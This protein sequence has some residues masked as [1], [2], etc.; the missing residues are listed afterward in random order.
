MVTQ[1]TLLSSQIPCQS[2]TNACYVKKHFN[3]DFEIEMELKEETDFIISQPRMLFFMDIDGDGTPEI[4]ASGYDDYHAKQVSSNTIIFI[5]SKSYQIKKKMKTYYYNDD[6]VNSLQVVKINSDFEIIIAVADVPE[7]PSNLRRRLVCYRSDNSI[8]WIS[9]DVLP[10]GFNNVSLADFNQDGIP[11]V[12]SYNQIYNADNGVL[13]LD[14]GN[15]YFN[16]PYDATRNSVAVNMD[17]NPNDLELVADF[18]VSKIIIT[19]LNGTSGNQIIPDIIIP[20]RNKLEMFVAVADMNLDGKLD[21]IMIGGGN[22]YISTYNGN[23]FEIITQINYN[24]Y[25]NTITIGNVNNKSQPCLI[26]NNFSGLTK[27]SLDSNNQLQLDWTYEPNEYYGVGCTLF[28]FDNDGI[29]E[30]LFRGNKTF[31][32]ISAKNDIPLELTKY[33]CGSILP[34]TNSPV[35]GDIDGTGETKICVPCT[36]RQYSYSARLTIFGAPEGQ[37]WA[38]ARRIWNHYLYNPLFINDDGTVPQYMHDIATYKNGKYNNF[39]AQESLL[40]EDGNYLAPAASLTGDISCIDYDV[41]SDSYTIHFSIHNRLDASATATTGVPISF[42]DGASGDMLGTFHTDQPIVAN[43]TAGTYSY[44]ISAGNIQTLYMVVNTD[45]YPLVLTDTI[46]YDIDECDYHDN[47]FITDLPQIE[48]TQQEICAGDPYEWWGTTLTQS[49][50]YTHRQLNVSGCDSIISLLQL[51]VTQLKMSEQSQSSCDTYT[52][53]EQTYDHSGSYTFDTQSINGCDSIAT[54]HLTLHHST[55]TE[56]QAESCD[57]Y[58]WNGQTYTQSGQYTY[59]GRTS[60]GCDSTVLVKLT[61]HPSTTDTLHYATCE[62]YQWNGKTYTQSGDYLYQGQTLHGCDS[63]VTLSLIIS[64]D[65]LTEER[66]TACDTYT[67]NGQTYDHSGSYTL[68]TQSING[69]DSIVTLQLTIHPSYHTDEQLITC[70]SISYLGQ[71]LDQSGVYHFP[72]QSSAGC[73]SIVTLDFI[74]ATSQ[75]QYPQTSCGAYLWQEDQQTY[76]QSGDYEVHYTNI[77]GCDSTL[78]L[79]LTIHPTYAKEITA[80]G[81]GSYQWQGQQYLQSGTYT[82]HLTTRMHCDSTLTLRLLI[83]AESEKHD[84]VTTNE[85]YYWEI[86]G[87]TYSESGIY[88]QVY[89]SDHQCDSIHY[90][91]LSIK[92]GTDIYFPNVINTTSGG[93]GYFTGYSI[94]KPV[95]I[96]VLTVYD[97]WGN[98]VYQADHLMTNEPQSGWDGTY[99]GR[100][101]QQG[102][103]VWIA[104]VRHRD[105]SET[106]YTGDVT[107]IR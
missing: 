74:I 73:D 43:G 26:L 45:Q 50:S 95:E 64:H 94:G 30:I 2:D 33:P 9:N 105:G 85:P 35:I 89:L 42:Y 7:N 101:A 28:D 100:V 82:Q 62:E 37:R 103:Y 107:V 13:L 61:I 1:C 88:E 46:R 24:N 22:L 20:D 79:R 98:V 3:S 97:R 54:L 66:L 18:S 16:P 29:Q 47:L 106:T 25:F 77:Y 83:Y 55:H 32:I 14:G 51:E 86:N 41:D 15:R 90:L 60:A 93:N 52:W 49:G 34:I 53:N 76:T 56:E 65:I 17:D 23:K 44:T 68:D 4:I 91:H 75:T 67:W 6:Y 21:V 5:D 12:Y 36:D 27:Y 63:L 102:V 57:V 81:C 10:S 78:M 8:K 92:D 96:T 84:T 39:M 11:E 99:R 87:V 59:T 31:K 19:N 80:T 72:L 58:T 69:C 38:P 48:R 40:D 70:A 71:T 104:K